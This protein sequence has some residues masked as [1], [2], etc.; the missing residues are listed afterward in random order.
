MKENEVAT[1]SFIRLH[2]DC[3]GWC[4]KNALR[5][6]SGAGLNGLKRWR[7]KATALKWCDGVTVSDSIV[8]CGSIE[9]ATFFLL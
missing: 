9:T 3:V 4:K 2:S 6:Q 5:G 7:R 8:P 1:P